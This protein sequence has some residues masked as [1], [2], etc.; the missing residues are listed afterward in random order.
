MS[1]YYVNE[2]Y[3]GEAFTKHTQGIWD[4]YV[5]LESHFIK[6]ISFER[7]RRGWEDTIKMNHWKRRDGSDIF[8]LAQNSL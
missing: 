5:I 7:C 8:K 1:H 6:M 4:A 3:I 2:D